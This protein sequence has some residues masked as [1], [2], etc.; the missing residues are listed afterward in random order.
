MGLSTESGPLP[1][2]PLRSGTS[3]PRSPS[4]HKP[5]SPSAG[6]FTLALSREVVHDQIDEEDEFDE[7]DTDWY[8]QMSMDYPPS[9][10]FTPTD[11]STCS[12]SRSSSFASY[13]SSQWHTKE[14]FEGGNISLSSSISDL[15]EPSN[16]YFGPQSNEHSVNYYNQLSPADTNFHLHVKPHSRSR[17]SLPQED[18]R[19]PYSSFYHLTETLAM[20]KDVSHSPSTS[21]STIRD[22]LHDL[23]G[24]CRPDSS[25]LPERPSSDYDEAVDGNDWDRNGSRGYRDDWDYGR[26]HGNAREGGRHNGEG[27]GGDRRAGA[28]GHNSGSG[29]GNRDRDGDDQR[30]RQPAQSSFSNP[31]DEEESEDES[32]DDYGMEETLPSTNLR[33]PAI[34]ESPGSTTTDD[35]IPLARKIPS[36]LQ[37]QKS[38]RKQVRDERDQRR[39]EKADAR[40]RLSPSSSRT[41]NTTQPRDSSSHDAG[42]HAS[43]S[44]Q[45]TIPSSNQRPFAVDDLTEKLLTV[46]AAGLASSAM[47]QPRVPRG[48]V[49]GTQQEDYNKRF[50]S[51]QPVG[52]PAAAASHL[53]PQSSQGREQ[54]QNSPSPLH[55]PTRGSSLEATAREHVPRP[56]RSL[57]ALA[58]SSKATEGSYAAHE[59]NNYGQK[60]GRSSTSVRPRR[61]E[62]S[63]VGVSRSGRASD[64]T[65]RPSIG[66][67]HS[68]RPSGELGA[69]GLQRNNTRPPMPPLPA[70]E[71]FNNMAHTPAPKIQMTQQRIFIEDKQRYQ[72]VEISPST[73]AGE[74]VEMVDSQA[75]LNKLGAGVGGWMLW[76]V[77]QDFGMGE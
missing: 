25:L 55:P 29:G 33:P 23:M 76:E 3:T 38:I 8:S 77:A 9:L 30:D 68:G 49:P 36:A 46:Q 12:L 51:N 1:S 71:V 65:R 34:S 37:A 13:T 41:A 72:M 5:C 62:E 27:A 59:D 6:D 22:S 39:K 57:H 16:D 11:P 54:Q 2:P 21:V 53:R 26:D 47:A 56:M 66:G 50:L 31:L 73:N 52:S 63:P 60:I 40:A 28:G 43:T 74:V 24:D 58:F 70:A 10:S 32:T 7:F 67:S 48:R 18:M 19:T 14:G 61:H 35:D 42:L 44:R 20:V 75:S 69:G 4:V 64:E 45:R 15:G 17:P